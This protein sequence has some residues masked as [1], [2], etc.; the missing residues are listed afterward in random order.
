[1]FR[2]D[3]PVMIALS[4]AADVMIVNIL[5]LICCIPVVTIGAAVAAMYTITLKMV[6]QDEYSVV[7]DFFTAF[8]SN[9]KQATVI[10]IILSL[11]ALLIGS[12]LYISYKLNVQY[13]RELVYAFLF[14]ALLLLLVASYVFPLQSKFENRVLSTMKNAVIM[15]LAHL[16]WSFVILIVNAV[17][18]IMLFMGEFF[19]RWGIP[20][21]FLCGFATIAWVNS[22]MFSKIFA[23]YIPNDL[24]VITS[25]NDM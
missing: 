25:G 12:F 24:T 6:N 1:M 3:N 9:F 10:W 22:R 14:L 18:V 21:L 15:S 17:P 16:P 20:L 5:F 19:F 2:L 13:Q 4:K 8:R 11:T 7:K 23:K